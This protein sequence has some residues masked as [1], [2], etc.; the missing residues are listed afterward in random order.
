MEVK[1]YH[2]K[3]PDDI[4]YAK[5]E[6]QDMPKNELLADLGYIPEDFPFV[7]VEVIA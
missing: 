4:G 1:Y 7:I 5:Y 2:I 3:E 6:E